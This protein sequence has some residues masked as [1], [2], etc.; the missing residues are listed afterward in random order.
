SIFSV[1]GFAGVVYIVWQNGDAETKKSIETEVLLYKHAVSDQKSALSTW[2]EKNQ[3]DAPGSIVI[4]KFTK[5]GLEHQQEFLDI[6][7]KIKLSED[8]NSIIDRIAYSIYYGGA[9][10]IDSFKNAYKNVK[11]KD[12]ESIYQKIT[13]LQNEKKG[14]D[15]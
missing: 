14:F 10:M 9:E 2:I 7:A 13:E 3:G 12:L 15:D 6:I 8:S 5:W 11:S 1:L 4:D